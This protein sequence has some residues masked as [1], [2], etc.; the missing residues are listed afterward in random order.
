MGMGNPL[1]AMF[2]VVQEM[3]ADCFESVLETVP[4][5]GTQPQTQVPFQ[6]K[7]LRWDPARGHI[8][9]LHC[10]RDLW[11]SVSWPR[12]KSLRAR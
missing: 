9:I 6:G 2:A 10:S 8:N 12:Q 1:L 11:A 5:R 3:A 4:W 7:N